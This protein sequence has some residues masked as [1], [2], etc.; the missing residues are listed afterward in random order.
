MTHLGDAHM[1]FKALVAAALIVAPAFAFAQ[2]AARVTTRERVRQSGDRL[3]DRQDVDKSGALEKPEWDKVTEDMVTR[4]RARMQK[5]FEDADANKDGKI[6][7]DEFLASRMKWF[8]DVDANHDGVLDRDELRG[9]N[10]ARA[11]QERGGAE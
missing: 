6:A 9:Y 11:R 8:D 7:R 4:L 5:R 10:R 2:D 3:F 1:T